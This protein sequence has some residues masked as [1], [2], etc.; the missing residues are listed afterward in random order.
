MKLP[1][2]TITPKEIDSSV[3]ILHLLAEST[4]LIR[5]GWECGMAL[6]EIAA[7]SIE[8]FIVPRSGPKWWDVSA[9]IIMVEEAGGKVTDMLGNPIIHHDLSKGLIAS[10][11]L[12]HDKILDIVQE[13][14]NYGRWI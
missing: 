13:G 4:G 7:G 8:A 10:N 14:G 5:D 1:R 2:V 9:G 3:R 12:L 6:A 11:G